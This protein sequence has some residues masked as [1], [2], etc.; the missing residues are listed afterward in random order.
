MTNATQISRRSILASGAAA[1]IAGGAALS[2]ALA[3]SAVSREKPEL[4]ALGGELDKAETAFLVAHDAKVRARAAFDAVCPAVPPELV[5]KVD[6]EIYFVHGEPEKDIEGNLKPTAASRNILTSGCLEGWAEDYGPRTKF[7]RL[8]RKKLEVV[9]DY[10]QRVAE[11]AAQTGIKEAI[12]ACQQAIKRIDI[13][14]GKISEINACSEDGILV[15]ARAI[16]TCGKIAN[17]HKIW[18]TVACGPGL[19]GD[20]SSVLRAHVG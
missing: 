9:R 4:I 17:Y 5:L 10:E 14:V 2:P 15:K 7:G 16:L 20:I 11:A 6:D 13:L 8:I 3:R 18:A 12:D 1:T 19:A